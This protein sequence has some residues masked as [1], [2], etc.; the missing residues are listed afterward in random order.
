MR[1]TFRVRYRTSFGQSLLLTG[2]HD[3]LGNGDIAKAIPLQYLDE[4]F[5]QFTIYMPKAAVPDAVIT[6]NYVLRNSDGSLIFDWGTDKKLNPAAFAK[7]E[8]LVIDSWNY[9]GAFENAFYTEPFKNVLLKHGKGINASAADRNVGVTHTFKVKAP[10]L[11]P[12]QTLCLLGSAAALQNWNTTTP[13]TLRQN[14]D[15]DF[16]SIP[17]DL[18]QAGFPLEYKYGVWDIESKTFVRFEDGPN[19]ILSEKAAP[20]KHS[21]VNDGFAALPC[22]SWKGAGVAIPVFSLR[23]DSSFGVGEFAD[24][25]LVADWCVRAGLKLIQILPINDTI[26]TGTWVDSYPYA[27]ISAFAL[28]PLY[29]NLG[30]VV[31]G[32]N[33]R[34][35]E[36]LEVERKRLNSLEAVDYE[37]VLNAKL[38]F[39]K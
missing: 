2:D 35:L 13:V 32:Q 36:E 21:I 10:L 16:L 15:D 4:Q 7:E 8:L 6:Y 5:W 9:A 19:R 33:K 37:A 29:L 3:M 24:L 27:A 25:K 28:H 11:G 38:K 12:N 23:S 34:L 14:A 31:T 39:L 20:H 30:Q 18:S 22:T 26:T 1:L 17:V